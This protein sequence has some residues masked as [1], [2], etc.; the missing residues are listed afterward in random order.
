MDAIKGV[1]GLFS[2]MKIED[3]AL[4]YCLCAIRYFEALLE[5]ELNSRQQ[6]TC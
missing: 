3:A 1:I 2:I 5:V 6:V 4:G